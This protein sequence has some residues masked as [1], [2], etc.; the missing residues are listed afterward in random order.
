MVLLIGA[1]T[2]DEA[3]L[4]IPGELKDEHPI[5]IKEIPDAFC[6]REAILQKIPME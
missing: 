5:L 1:R 3:W 2:R 4:K 6:N